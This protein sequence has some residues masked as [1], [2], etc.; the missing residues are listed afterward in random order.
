MILATIMTLKEQKQLEDGW[1]SNNKEPEYTAM[2]LDLNLAPK[3][4]E[5]AKTILTCV[6]GVTSMPLVYVVRHHHIPDLEEDNPA[7]G[8]VDTKYL[9]HDQEMI[10]RCPIMREEADYDLTY[11][12][13]KDNRPFILSFLTNSKKVW[14]ILHA[15]FSASGAWQHVKKSRACRMVATSGV[16]FTAISLGVTR[17]ILCTATS[18]RPSSACSMVETARITTSKSYV[19]PT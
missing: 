18:S 14:A 4:F 7:F 1:L 17:L 12:E 11:Y 8:E 9:S 6:W 16:L 2:T 5:R 3:T 19:L 13:L 10:A 15:L